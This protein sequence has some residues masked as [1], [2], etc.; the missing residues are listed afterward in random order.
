MTNDQNAI[1]A[2]PDGNEKFLGTYLEAINDLQGYLPTKETFADAIEALPEDTKD[3]MGVLIR[4]LT[5]KKRGIK[6]VSDTN[7]LTILRMYQGSGSDP[8]RPEKQIPGELYTSL[9]VN[10]GD[11]IKGIVL[12]VWEARAMWDDDD[13]GAPKCQSGDRVI[14]STYGECAKCMHRPWNNGER[15]ACQDTIN[16]IMLLADYSDIVQVTFAKS[17]L[18][19]GRQLL[20]FV[21]GTEFPWDNIIKLT[22]QKKTSDEGYLWYTFQCGIAEATETEA[23][24]VIDYI[25]AMMEATYMYPSIA[26]IYEQAS[27]SAE[28]LS[29]EEEEAEGTVPTL[30]DDTSLEEESEM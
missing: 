28:E 16:V 4:K 26:R 3:A 17:S 13:R 8:M 11:S 23:K 29:T 18:K 7:Q 22:T 2:L 20:K 1:V 15:T 9:G 6:T 21:K 24:P 19:S 10:M 5:T 14:G 27:D 30:E 12:A 25:S